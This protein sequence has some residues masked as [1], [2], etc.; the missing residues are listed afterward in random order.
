MI[1][2]DQATY[3][4]WLRAAYIYYIKPGDD[5]GMTDTEWDSISRALYRARGEIQEE[6]FP[7]VYRNEFTGGSIFWLKRG[8]YPEEA[9]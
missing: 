7:V 8:E 9:R 2:L 4:K 1:V 6:L 3:I 5:P